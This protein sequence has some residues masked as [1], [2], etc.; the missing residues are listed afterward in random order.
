MNRRR[1]LIQIVHGPTHKEP[2]VGLEG[3]RAAVGLVRA[4]E[5]HAVDLVF[6]DEGVRWL[7]GMREP[8]ADAMLA[9]LRAAGVSC[10]VVA[11]DSETEADFAADAR[12][13]DA[14]ALAQVIERAEV[15]LRY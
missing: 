9:Q 8:D 2:D 15:T 14:D 13:L 6:S 3:L 12:T 7:Q 11:P 10:Y 5:S 1:V 4:T